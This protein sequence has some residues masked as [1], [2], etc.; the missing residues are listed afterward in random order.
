MK[1]RV[2]FEIVQSV[3]TKEVELDEYGMT[4]EEWDKMSDEEKDIWLYDEVLD[5]MDIPSF[6]VSS[7]DE[8]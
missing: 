6:V 2:E 7:K 8:L 3:I 1:I 4:Q 5:R